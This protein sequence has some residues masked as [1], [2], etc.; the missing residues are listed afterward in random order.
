MTGEDP[1][2]G[3]RWTTRVL[4]ICAAL[5]AVQAIISLAATAVTP[6]IAAT[7]P[8]IYALVAAVHSAMPFLARILTDARW[9]AALTA[10]ITGVLVWPF[11][12]V[13]PLFAVVVL[14][15]AVSFD[16]ALLGIR[17]PGRRRM[18]PAALLAGATLFLVSLPVFSPAHLTPVILTAT[19]LGRIGGETIA[20]LV[21]E[22]LASGLSQAGARVR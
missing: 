12:A 4:L 15:G 6:A 8:P 22:R 19:L 2:D 5:A 9:S 20:L 13:G 3:S 7:A 1:G 17:R 14:T 10:A 11:S 16:L 18:L 21:A